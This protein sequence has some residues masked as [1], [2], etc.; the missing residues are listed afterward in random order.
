[1]PLVVPCRPTAIEPLPGTYPA[2]PP[3]I[4]WV[5]RG[6]PLQSVKPVKGALERLSLRKR[7]QGLHD[8]LAAVYQPR[9]AHEAHNLSPVPFGAAQTAPKEVYQRSACA[10]QTFRPFI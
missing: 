8:G 9:V 3:P 2:R 4:R 10:S 7:E 6:N 1:M 5:R